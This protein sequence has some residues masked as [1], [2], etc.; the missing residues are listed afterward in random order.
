MEVTCFTNKRPKCGFT[1]NLK[2]AFCFIYDERKS[3]NLLK[4]FFYSC[5]IEGCCDHSLSHKLGW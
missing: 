1:E 5:H 3:I 4:N 2:K